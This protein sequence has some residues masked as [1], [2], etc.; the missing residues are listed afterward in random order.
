[1]YK[2]GPD[3]PT[4]P[5]QLESLML[6]DPK[7]VLMSHLTSPETAQMVI[8]YTD[9]ARFY[10]GLRQKDTFAGLK[11]WAAAV[12]EPQLAADSLA[13]VI[14][15]RLLRKLCP[16][17]RIAY[18]PDP[19]LLKKLNLPAERVKQ[20]YKHSGKVMV[21]DQEQVCETCVGLGYLGRRAVYEVMPLD[22]ECRALIGQRQLDQLKN[23]LRKQGMLYMQEA[24]L[25]LAAEGVTS[26]SEISRV[27]ADK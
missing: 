22:D 15:L 1:M 8:K 2:K 17:C 5:K 10:L 13:G 24:A 4:I 16:T 26:V 20:L 12:D 6:R 18:K 14:S 3:A 27:L 7:V 19:A 23:R 25:T 21:K 11:A 9:E